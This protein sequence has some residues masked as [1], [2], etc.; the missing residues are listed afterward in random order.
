MVTTKPGVSRKAAQWLEESDQAKSIKKVTLAL[1]EFPINQ[2][3][4]VKDKGMKTG[5]FLVT[6]LADLPSREVIKHYAER[7]K[8]EHYFEEIKSSL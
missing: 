1:D 2:F 3:I 5:W 6:N 7:W 8:I 4:C